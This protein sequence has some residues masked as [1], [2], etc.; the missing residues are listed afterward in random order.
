LVEG[1]TIHE[2]YVSG[3][4]VN[5]AVNLSAS[6]KVEYLLDQVSDCCFLKDF[7]V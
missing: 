2:Y 1:L 7:P 4:F 6:I 3:D 5:M